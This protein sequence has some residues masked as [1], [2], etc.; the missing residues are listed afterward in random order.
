VVLS[1]DVIRALLDRKDAKE[2]IEVSGDVLE[3]GR[4]GEDW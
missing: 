1:A 2:L 3:A 4:T